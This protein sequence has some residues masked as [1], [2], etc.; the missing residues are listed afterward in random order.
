[1]IGKKSFAIGWDVG[2]W[3]CDRNPRSRDA[4]V[5]LNPDLQITGTPWRGNLRALINEAQT[6]RDWINGLFALCE[7]AQPSADRHVFLAID[8]PL[9]FSQAFIDLT[10][11]CRPVPEPLDTSQTNPYLFRHTEQL[12]FAHGLRPL[13]AVKDLI[14]SQATKGMHVLAKFA[15]Q[16]AGCGVWT[17]GVS[18]SAFEAYPAAC[19]GS[20][21]IA[22]MRAGYPAVGNQDKEDALTC[23]LLAALLASDQEQLWGPTVETPISEGWIWVP[24]D[25]IS[26]EQKCL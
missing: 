4:I 3:N 18:L 9:A 11:H 26:S 1:M 17:D 16:P 6:G 7:A 10:T 8:T 22:R 25:V 24:E 23:A 21:T 14:G 19:K 13:S 20:E 2:G 12:L 5:I 15:P